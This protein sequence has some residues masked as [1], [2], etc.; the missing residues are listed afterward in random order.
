MPDEYPEGR[1]PD[2]KVAKRRGVTAAQLQ[3]IQERLARRADELVG[4]EMVFDLIEEAKV[5]PPCGPPV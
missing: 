3:A 5:R 1:P 2:V 4:S